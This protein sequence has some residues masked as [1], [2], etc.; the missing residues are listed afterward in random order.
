ME[1]RLGR[2]CILTVEHEE[3]LATR[4]LDMESRL[5]GYIAKRRRRPLAIR[6][7]RKGDL[8]PIF[9]IDLETVNRFN[10]HMFISLNQSIIRDFRELQDMLASNIDVQALQLVCTQIYQVQA[11]KAFFTT[12]IDSIVF[13]NTFIDLTGLKLFGYQPC[14]IITYQ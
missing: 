5:Y 8:R 7:I 10:V 14:L 11:R 9:S 4:L 6:P 13:V 12:F 2:H 1:K 3:D